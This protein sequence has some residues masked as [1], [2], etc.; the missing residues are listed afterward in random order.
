M[1]DEPT[2]TDVPG[3]G[4]TAPVE[5]PTETE[6]A[7]AEAYPDTFQLPQQPKAAT[8]ATKKAAG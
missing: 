5:P 4:E 1:P 7:L 8:K 6:L 2:T 3:P